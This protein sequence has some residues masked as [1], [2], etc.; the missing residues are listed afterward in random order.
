[1]GDL[2]A[3]GRLVD[4]ILGLVVAEAGLV[5]AYRSRTGRG[6]AFVD[7]LCN[8]LAGAFLLLA[9][10]AALTQAGWTWIALNLSAALAAHLADLRRRWQR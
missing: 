2:I 8:Q 3:S 6:V 1:M 9:L 5:L 10:R 4:L 7:L